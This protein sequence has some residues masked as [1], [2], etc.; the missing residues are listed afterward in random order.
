M[1]RTS[2]SF[3][4]AVAA[5]TG[6]GQVLA[7]QEA[8]KALVART[9]PAALSARALVMKCFMLEDVHEAPAMIAM[10]LWFHV[11]IDSFPYIKNLE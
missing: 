3:V 9:S 1:L 6:L 5:P 11:Y 7:S 4:A 10:K 8:R 2:I